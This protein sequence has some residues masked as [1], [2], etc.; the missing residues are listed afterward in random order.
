MSTERRRIPVYIDG[1]HY[2]NLK[3]GVLRHINVDNARE[4]QIIR[5]NLKLGRAVHYCGHVI[6]A[7]ANLTIVC[8]VEDI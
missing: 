7:A 3:D 4:R 5:G 8:S 6:V 2:P 1:T